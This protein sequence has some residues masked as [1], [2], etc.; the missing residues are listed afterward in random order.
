M[1]D[2]AQAARADRAFRK[3]ARDMIARAGRCLR[4]AVRTVIRAVMMAH[5]EQ[6]RMWECILLASGAAPPT[7]ANWA[8]PTPPGS[9]PRVYRS[10]SRC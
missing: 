3:G 10:V 7:A 2:L 4:P 5:H 8:S 6:V 9:R 1:I